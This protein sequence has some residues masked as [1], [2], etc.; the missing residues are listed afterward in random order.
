MNCFAQS[1]PPKE[2]HFIKDY[3][4][5]NFYNSQVILSQLDF[6]K[7]ILDDPLYKLNHQTLPGCDFKLQDGLLNISNNTKTI[8]QSHINLGKIFNYAAID[9]DIEAQNK[10]SSFATASLSIFKDNRNR[11]TVS[12]NQID[13]ESKQIVFE[14]FK[15]GESV[16]KEILFGKKLKSPN[17]LRVHLTGKSSCSFF[18]FFLTFLCGKLKSSFPPSLHF[19][20]IKYQ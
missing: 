16:L 12:Q 19:L 14:I 7:N 17:T 9:M 3:Q 15:E 18:I 2:L 5:R 8:Q 6:S 11:L 1:I 13:P 20:F 10:K 4:I